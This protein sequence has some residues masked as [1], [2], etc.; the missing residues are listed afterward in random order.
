[1]M[2]PY[3]LFYY[4]KNNFFRVALASLHRIDHDHHPT[5]S[6]ESNNNIIIVDCTFDFLNAPNK[7]KCD[8]K[9][10]PKAKAIECIAAKTNSKGELVKMLHF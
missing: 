8:T 4:F 3:K 1:M 7:I 2:H 6:K 10:V 5:R 9:L